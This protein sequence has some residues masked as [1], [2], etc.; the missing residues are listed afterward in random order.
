MKALVVYYSRTGNTRAAAKEI[1]S[2]LNADVEELDDGVDRKGLIGWLKAGRDGMKKAKVKLK[3]LK[4]NPAEYDLIVV[5]SPV[6]GGNITPAVRTFLAEN[7]LAGKKV[8]LF[9][10]T[11]SPTPGEAI[12]NMKEYLKGATIVGEKSWRSFA[13]KELKNNAIEWAKSLNN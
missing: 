1:A 13:N 6:W 2:A 3:P 4:H 12:T 7:N 10:T 5:G 9:C 11:G 8:A